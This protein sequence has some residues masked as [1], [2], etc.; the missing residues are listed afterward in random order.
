MAV[1][2]VAKLQDELVILF[3]IVIMRYAYLNNTFLFEGNAVLPVGD[4]AIQRGYAIFDFL[5]VDRDV[6]VFLADH[7]DRFF[8]SAAKMDLPMARSQAELSA[9]IH[10][11]ISRNRMGLSGIRLTLTG[12]VSGDGYSISEPNL[13]ITQSPLQER[14][15]EL[16]EHGM[17]LITYPYLRQLPD[18]KTI[19][20]IMAIRLQKLI[21][22][23]GVNDVLYV[24]EGLI[25]ECPR[26]NFFM[27]SADGEL[28]T[29]D[30]GILEG[31]TRK[32]VLE[33]GRRHFKVQERAVHL[34]ELK[35]AREA[36]ITSTTKGVVPVVAVDNLPIG[37]GRPGEIT[38]R[39]DAELA[40]MKR[41]YGR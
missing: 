27:V 29:P 22:E 41:K 28:I 14:S 34:E 32:K 11:L 35:A 36:F 3:K 15:A 37:T 13:I 20:Y 8:R 10:E 38:R 12:G 33:I 24:H 2:T 6:P 30:T 21:R 17:K 5:K 23:Q 1:Q 4:L 9:I 18:V 31:I 7:L 39:L 40:E 16:V 19:D 26:T 25:S